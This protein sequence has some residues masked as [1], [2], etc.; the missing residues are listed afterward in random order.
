MDGCQE[1]EGRCLLCRV[2]CVQNLAVQ[3]DMEW[4]L[5]R[6]YARTRMCEAIDNRSSGG[7]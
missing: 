1:Q 6:F 7:A 5:V 3:V 2:R 4:R